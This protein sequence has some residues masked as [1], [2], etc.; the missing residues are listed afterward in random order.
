M[1]P[2]SHAAIVEVVAASGVKGKPRA[3]VGH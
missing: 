2:Q 1:A 3:P